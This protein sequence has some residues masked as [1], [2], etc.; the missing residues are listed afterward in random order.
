METFV[1]CEHLKIYEHY[2]MPWKLFE[3]TARRQDIFIPD[4]FMSRIQQIN[5]R[6]VPEK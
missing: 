2:I 4:F 5:R 1:F 3:K 6:R